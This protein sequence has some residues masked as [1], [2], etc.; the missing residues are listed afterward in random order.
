[1]TVCCCISDM[2]L[3]QRLYGGSTL[4]EPFVHG[5]KQLIDHTGTSKYEKKYYA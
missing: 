4:F 2:Q 1:M 5:Y 3:A